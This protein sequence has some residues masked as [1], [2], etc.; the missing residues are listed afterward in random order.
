MGLRMGQIEVYGFF[1]GK[2]L[3][4]VDTYFSVDKVRK[5]LK[6]KGLDYSRSVVNDDV[7]KLFWFGYLEMAKEFRGVGLGRK[8]VE[9]YRLKRCYV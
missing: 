6:S 7:K 4:G 5:E 2:R 9:C 1:K 8:N 3:I